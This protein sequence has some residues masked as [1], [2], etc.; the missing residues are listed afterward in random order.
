MKL[1]IKSICISETT[2]HYDREKGCKIL[3]FRAYFCFPRE[4]NKYALKRLNAQSLPVDDDRQS[5]G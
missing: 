1:Y 2:I 3:S 4:K 5:Y